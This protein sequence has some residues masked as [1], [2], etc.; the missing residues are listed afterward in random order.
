MYLASI[1]INKPTVRS[2]YEARK[3]NTQWTGVVCFIFLRL[4]YSG[5]QLNIVCLHAVFFRLHWGALFKSSTRTIACS[6]IVRLV[7]L[8]YFILPL[9]PELCVYVC[10][11][12]RVCACACLCV[13]ARARVYMRAHVCACARVGCMCVC[14]RACLE[15]KVQAFVKGRHLFL[16]CMTDL[17]SPWTRIVS[18]VFLYVSSN[19]TAFPE[20][21]GSCCD[22]IAIN[23]LCFLHR[24]L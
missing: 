11:C 21:E 18:F 14:A 23:I 15:R 5:R 10:V 3:M 17:Y 12:A 8:F 19:V 6:R 22:E 13:C 7:K 2:L 16:S 24:A 20:T 4:S 9:I 1:Q